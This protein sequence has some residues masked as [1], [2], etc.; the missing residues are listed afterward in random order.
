MHIGVYHF[1]SRTKNPRYKTATIYTIH[2]L[3]RNKKE[4][5]ESVEI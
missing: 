5:L 2:F 4:T 3:D 1:V